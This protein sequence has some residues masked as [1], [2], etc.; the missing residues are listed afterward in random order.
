M[1]T[2][3]D[4]ATTAEDEAL[5]EE[6]GMAATEDEITADERTTAEDE[7]TAAGE[8][9]EDVDG[10]GVITITVASPPGVAGANVMVLAV[11]P[12]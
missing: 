8:G 2:A 5:I 6:D 10:S 4:E 1:L 11:L 9:M 3:G 12:L 7:M